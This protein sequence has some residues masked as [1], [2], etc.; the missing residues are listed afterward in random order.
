MQATPPAGRCPRLGKMQPLASAAARIS[1]QGDRTLTTVFDSSGRPVQRNV[2]FH[3]PVS[4][5][6]IADPHPTRQ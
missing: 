4:P 3:R 6:Q 2:Q 1:R 5:A